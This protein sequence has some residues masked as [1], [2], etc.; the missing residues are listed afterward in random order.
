MPLSKFIVK[1]ITTEQTIAVRQPVLRAGRPREDCYFQG[2]DLST[3]VHYGV[4]AESALA[5]IATFLEQNN[6]NFDGEHLQLRGMAVLDEFKEKGIGK[7]LLETGELLARIKEKNLIW[8][9]ARI[10]AVPFYKKMGYTTVGYTFE[11][12]LVGV[13]YVMKKELDEPQSIYKIN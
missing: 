6:T 1:K 11:I 4:F 3:T 8:C 2:D 13:H 9:N 10:L 5:G 7:L 12:P